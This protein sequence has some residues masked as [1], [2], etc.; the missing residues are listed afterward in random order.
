MK[1]I[2]VTVKIGSGKDAI[3]KERRF[4]PSTPARVRKAWKAATRAKLEKKF[5][6]QT[7][8]AV[9]RD[10]LAADAER[11][12]KL[13]RHLADWVTR[14]S[15]IR[16]W[17]PELGDTHRHM[18]TREDVL[19]VRGLWVVQGRAAKTINNRVTALRNLFH[20]LDGDQEPTPCDG[21]RP[22]TSARVPPQVITADVV[23]AVAW[24]LA[25]SKAKHAEADRGRLMVL[26]STG[27]RP[28]ELERAQ[29]A[30]VD[31]LRR[32]WAVRDAKGGWSEGL[33]LND[34]M[35][36]AWGVFIAANAWGPFPDHF[37]RRLRTAGWPEGVRPYNLRHSTW[38]EASERGADLADIQAG[39]G[40]RNMATTRQHYVPVLRSRMQRLSERLEGR[41]GWEREKRLAG[42]AGT[43]QKH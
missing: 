20:L 9:K 10:R 1:M 12:Y 2:R 16:A 29:P 30:D 38:I 6:A 33:Y 39:A 3:Q 11:Y 28:C 15:E 21:I 26:A 8:R 40:H 23:N 19:R 35:V 17:L 25:A 5:S 42:E 22:L 32:V 13:I 18:I 41:F 4:S 24:R 37:P 31:L 7:D 34:E 27:K 36:L 43:Q 14:R